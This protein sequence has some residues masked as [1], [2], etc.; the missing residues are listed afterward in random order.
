MADEWPD[1]DDLMDAARIAGLGVTVDDLRRS[2]NP[3]LKWPA[4]S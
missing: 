2:N 3:G 4:A 1:Y